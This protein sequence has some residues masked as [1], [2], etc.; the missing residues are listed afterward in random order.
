MPSYTGVVE[1]EHP[2]AAV[3]AFLAAFEHTAEWD[4]SC[5]RAQRTTTGEPTLGSRF[6]LVFKLIGPIETTLTYEIVALNSPLRVTLRG[7]NAQLHSEDTIGVE[8]NDRGS[9]VTYHAE[10]GL[11]GPGKVLDPLIGLGFQR[12]G[13][14]AERG[15]RERLSRPL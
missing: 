8:A 4:P 12:A 3:F 11:N 13:Q 2:A 9:R 10:I 5:D 15:L 6:D 1:C 7:G 14:Q